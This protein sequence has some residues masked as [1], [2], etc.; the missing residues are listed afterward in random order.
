KPRDVANGYLTCHPCR[1]APFSLVGDPLVPC[2]LPGPAGR[3]AMV[4]SVP[5]SFAASVPPSF[6]ASVPPSFAAS[7]T[8]AI[9]GHDPWLARRGMFACDAEYHAALTVSL[10]KNY[11]LDRGLDR[12]RR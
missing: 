7:V 9:S 1:L 11:N 6:A 4:E 3:P 10:H 5:P 2:P 12:H 8:A